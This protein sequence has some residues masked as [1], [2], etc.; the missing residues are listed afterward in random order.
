[1]TRA[2]ALRIA[3]SVQMDV[4]PAPVPPFFR[5]QSAVA[6]LVFARKESLDLTPIVLSA[7]PSFLEFTG[8]SFYASAHYRKIKCIAGLNPPIAPQ[9][10]FRFRTN[11]E[12]PTLCCEVSGNECRKRW[13]ESCTAPERFRDSPPPRAHPPSGRHSE[14][15]CRFPP[16]DRRCSGPRSAADVCRRS[17][18]QEPEC[19]FSW[20]SRCL[21]KTYA[22]I[23]FVLSRD[24]CLLR[25]RSREIEKE[26]MHEA[27]D[28]A[29]AR[30]S[31]GSAN[32]T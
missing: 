7:Y 29:S 18:F 25:A 17:Q 8:P 2:F 21:N 13:T 10:R 9:S 6:K 14:T 32:R 31:H 16:T 19:E 11:T 30:Q 1:M 12:V 24:R 26:R 5:R 23:G 22:W 4:M 20:R 27:V 15:G 3:K 28:G